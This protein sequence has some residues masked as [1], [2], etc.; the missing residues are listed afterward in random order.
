MSLFFWMGG[1][2]Q[3]LSGNPKNEEMLQR[4]SKKTSF[5]YS[6]W[7]VKKICLKCLKVRFK[8]S[9]FIHEIEP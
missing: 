8:K 2:D 5:I 7:K 1:M 6:F 9:N 3:F 4:L